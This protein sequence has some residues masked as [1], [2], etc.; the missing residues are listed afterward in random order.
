MELR[1]QLKS[2]DDQKGFGFIRPD[3]GGNEVFAHIS[4]MRGARRPVQGDRV[5]YGTDRDR[6]GRLR[7]S[8]IRLD[9]LSLDDPAIRQKP[10]ARR[11]PKARHE[12][13]GPRARR[14]GA[15]RQHFSLKVS[16]LVLLCLLP[17]LGSVRLVQQGVHW[18]LVAYALASLLVFGLYLHDK[19]S[20]MRGNRRTPEAHLH[21]VELLGGWPGA[22]LAQQV[23][24][25]KTR[26][27]SFQLAFWLIVMAHQVVWL[28]YLYFQRLHEVLLGLSR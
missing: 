28:D 21:L 2:W 25:H 6:E 11:S 24:R 20:A 8:H 27:L 5:R 13:H 17:T 4:V 3:N 10:L 1:G 26:K 15:L 23:L 18:P 7:A 9:T 12:D 22:L 14:V 16:A 19:R